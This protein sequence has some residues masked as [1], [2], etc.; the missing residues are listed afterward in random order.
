L[1]TGQKHQEPKKGGNMPIKSIE[2]ICIPC[3]KCDSM[4]NSI[5]LAIKNL[6]LRYKIKIA[7]EFKHTPTLKDISKYALNPSQIPAV[8]INGKPEFGGSI[9]QDMVL[10]KLDSIHKMGY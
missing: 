8:L 9:R 1:I 6:E 3:A 2:I 7:Y 4:K 10:A 5:A